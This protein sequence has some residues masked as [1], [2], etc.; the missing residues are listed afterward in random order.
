MPKTCVIAATTTK[1]SPR[2]PPT[3]NTPT[4]PTTQM[5]SAKHAI[6]LNTTSKGSKRDSKESN[7]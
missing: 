2:W 5:V 1:V 4:N 6:W 3:A 7:L